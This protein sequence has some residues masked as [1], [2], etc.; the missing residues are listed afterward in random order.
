MS[1]REL[2]EHV[3]RLAPGT[4]VLRMSGFVRAPNQ[5]DDTTYLQK[6]FSTQD[7]LVKVKQALTAG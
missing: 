5:E 3:H 4:R 7:L 1:G 6:P 2:V